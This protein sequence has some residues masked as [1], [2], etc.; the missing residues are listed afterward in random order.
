MVDTRR[1][2][3]SGSEMNTEQ[4]ERS[5]K[6]EK[7]RTYQTETRSSVIVE[8]KWQRASRAKHGGI[9]AGERTGRNA[10][11]G[12]SV[13]YVTGRFGQTVHIL[14]KESHMLR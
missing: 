10:R 11:R 13:V 7:H 1:K 5:A 9:S 3:S 14:C 2:C 6:L 4:P 8:P 12:V